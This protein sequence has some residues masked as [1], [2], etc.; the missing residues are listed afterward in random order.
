MTGERTRKYMAQL[1]TYLQEMNM[2]EGILLYDNKGNQEYAD[3]YIARNP[4]YIESLYE[5]LQIMQNDFWVKGLLPPWTGGADSKHP[6]AR[7]KPDEIVSVEEMKEK[8]PND[9]ALEENNDY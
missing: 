3:F 2:D 9:L 8:F 6:L 5:R 4:E 1:Q 7:H